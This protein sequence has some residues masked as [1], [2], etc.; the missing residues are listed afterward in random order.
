METGELLDRTVHA[1]FHV[2][3]DSKCELEPVTT[4]P[5]RMEV[6]PVL[7]VMNN[8][9]PVI[10]LH[11]LLIASKRPVGMQMVHVV[12]FPSHIGVKNTTNAY[13]RVTINFG[14]ILLKMVLNGETVSLQLLLSMETG[15]PLERTVHVLDHVEVDSRREL[16]PVTNLPL[17][18]E[19]QPVLV[20][21]KT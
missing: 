6:L 12:D 11:A 10:Q 18:M 9:S 17:R 16:E 2:V 19:V 15:D 20:V 21:T 1:L 13:L 7:V 5:L 8:E 4:L 14:A 3:V